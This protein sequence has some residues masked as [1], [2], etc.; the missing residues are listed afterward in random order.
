MWL[1]EW[2]R[3][4]EMHSQWTWKRLAIDDGSLI[5][6]D[7][8][9]VSRLWHT[10]EQHRLMWY[11]F[12][13]FH[14]NDEDWPLCRWSTLL[15]RVSVPSN[16]WTDCRYEDG[17][18]IQMF[19][20]DD[21]VNEAPARITDESDRC[22]WWRRRDSALNAI[23]LDERQLMEN[24]LLFV[25]ER[26]SADN[27]SAVH[28]PSRVYVFRNTMIVLTNHGTVLMCRKYVSKSRSFA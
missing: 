13:A 2:V 12:V 27:S 15:S 26:T 20:L 14:V 3:E 6:V 9:Q 10:L 21:F 16:D 23:S 18:V 11:F 24:E 22:K 19:L 8:W 1:R 17:S 4:R 25:W 28:I 5:S 7:L